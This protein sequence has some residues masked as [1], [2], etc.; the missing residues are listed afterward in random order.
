MTHQNKCFVVKA[1]KAK[2]KSTASSGK[3]KGKR[4]HKKTVC[5]RSQSGDKRI[6]GGRG[7]VK[8]ERKILERKKAK[9]KST[10]SSG[11]IKGKRRRMTPCLAL[12]NA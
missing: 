10:T 1:K 12:V 5:M 3:I 2:A 8:I 11:K 9:A 4:R 6:R 7:A